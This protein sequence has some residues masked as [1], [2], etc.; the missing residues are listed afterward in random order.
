MKLLR[1]ALTFVLALF[2]LSCSKTFIVFD[3]KSAESDR[4][5]LVFET[6]MGGGTLEAKSYNGQK[7]SWES[8][9]AGTD[10]AIKAGETRLIFDGTVWQGGRGYFA[11]DLSIDYNFEKGKTYYIFFDLVGFKFEYYIT[12]ENKNRLRSW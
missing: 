12:D 5:H 8:S 11:K 10:V 1:L 2:S 4:A 6:T 7:V 9:F 3:E